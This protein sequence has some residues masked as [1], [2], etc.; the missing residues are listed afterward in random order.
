MVLEKELRELEEM[1]AFA[2]LKVDKISARGIDWHLDHSLRII[3]NVSDFL[4]DSDPKAYKWKFSFIRL[5]IFAKGSIPRGKAKSPKAVNNK[6]EINF[7]D[8]TLL[9]KEVKSKVK[10]LE[11]LPSGANFNH[12]YFGYLKRDKTIKFLSIHTDH[13]YKIMKD[14]KNA[15]SKK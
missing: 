12:P 15:H 10:G 9:L 6:E 3:N 1:M 14:I 4:R 2:N 5:V 11:N 13:H 7:E 8:L